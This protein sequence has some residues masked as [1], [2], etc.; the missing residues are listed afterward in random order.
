M[1]IFPLPIQHA[2]RDFLICSF[3]RSLRAMN[4]HKPTTFSRQLALSCA[5]CTSDFGP[6]GPS[7][8]PGFFFPPS[9]FHVVLGHLTL[10]F[11]SSGCH[12]IATMQSSFLSSLSTWPNQFHLPVLRISSLIFFRP[13]TWEI[14][15]FRMRCGRQ[16]LRIHLGHVN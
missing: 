10:L 14:V 11:P 12:S 15:S 16:I 13:V 7:L 2:H 1:K 3:V 9:F 6:A 4:A 8:L 5:R